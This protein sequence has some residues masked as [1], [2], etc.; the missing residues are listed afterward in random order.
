M[1]CLFG[2]RFSL[3][4]LDIKHR[5]T[6]LADLQSA[7][8]DFLFLFFFLTTRRKKVD[9]YIPYSQQKAFLYS[10]YVTDGVLIKLPKV[11]LIPETGQA[12]KPH[13]G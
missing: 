3:S 6:A 1:C 10:S 8:S 13:I 4:L 9:S 12:C 5:K 11:T 7:L 2:A